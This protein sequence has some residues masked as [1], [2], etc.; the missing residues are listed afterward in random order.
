MTDLTQGPIARHLLGMAAFI[1]AGL[2]FQSA[3]FI[4]DLYFVSQLGRDAVAG[5]AA[6]GN[7][8][9][10]ALAGA[11]LVSVGALSLISQAIGRKDAAYASLVFNQVLVLSLMF[12]VAALVLGYGFAGAASASLGASPATAEFGRLY[13]YG[14]LPSLAAMF[15]GNV[16]NAA[17]RALGVVRPTMIL[18]TGSVLANVILAPVLIA[19]WGTG[20]PL[21]VFGAGLA[22]SIAS[23]AGL[24]AVGWLWP[25]LQSQLHVC[26]SE[27]SPRLAI[28]QS[29]MR[30]GLPAA[31]EFLL[32]FIIT[33]V[34]YIAIRRYG[35]VAQA[36]Y[37]IGARVMQ[38]L[39]L[40]VMAIAFA[41]APIAGQ[42]FGAKLRPRVIE[43]FR[44]SLLFGTGCMIVLTAI[45]QWLP[46]ML[47]SPFTAD[48]AVLA[49]ATQFL[50]TVSWNF[51]SVG[52]VFACNGMFQAMGDTRPSFISSASRLITFAVPALLLAAWPPAVLGDF[53]LTSN[54]SAAFQAVFSLLLL[55]RVFGKKL[56]IRTEQGARPEGSTH[57]IEA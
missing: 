46:E 29:L 22:S 44:T 49:I 38:A 37:G 19:G 23:L 34:I 28:W 47:C 40:P 1:A 30:V 32:M 10:L 6:A 21:G 33:A 26:R 36:G 7:F 25:R 31:G 45:C 51:V 52:A 15:P 18:Q 12:T 16:L 9:F 14:F 53:W 4:V 56:P 42:N 8:F 35:P 3:Y 13:L 50:R 54:L 20:Y 39:F 57:P 48:P 43:T 2:A 11:Q 17:L 55:R 5:V 24:L 41:A 27:L